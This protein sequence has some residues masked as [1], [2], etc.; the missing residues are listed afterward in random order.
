M[1][2]L[3]QNLYPVL[4]VHI[5]HIHWVGI[6]STTTEN[7]RSGTWLGPGPER[8]WGREWSRAALSRPRGFPVSP[9]PHLSGC[10]KKHTL[11]NQQLALSHLVDNIMVLVLFSRPLIRT[12]LELTRYSPSSSWELSEPGLHHGDPEIVGHYCRSRRSRPWWYWWRRKVEC[13][14]LIFNRKM[15]LAVCYIMCSIN[16]SRKVCDI[17]VKLLGLLDSNSNNLT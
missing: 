12:C 10:P 17:I 1:F 6:K 7:C 2:C 9:S 16:H 3:H 15:S 13:N 8:R 11:R 14:V 4:T 5:W